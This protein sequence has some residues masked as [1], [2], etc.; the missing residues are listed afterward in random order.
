M[1]E[2]YNDLRQFA[3]KHGR[4]KWF[5]VAKFAWN[6][7]KDIVKTK[8]ILKEQEEVQKLLSKYNKGHQTPVTK[9]TRTQ[10]QIL[11]NPKDSCICPVCRQGYISFSTQWRWQTGCTRKCAANNSQ[12][13]NKAKETMVSKYGV[14]NPSLSNELS[15]K[16][17]RTVRKRY[18]VKNAFQSAEL[19]K[20]ARN[21]MKERYGVENPS[22]SKEILDRKKETSLRNCGYSHWTQD[23]NQQD[24]L[25]P[26]SQKTMKKARNTMKERYGVE[27]PFYLKSVQ[28]RIKKTMLERYGAT[29]IFGS[30]GFSERSA[31]T[32]KERYGKYPWEMNNPFGCK[33]YKDKNG[34]VHHVQGHEPWAL[35]WLESRPYKV[36]VVTG[37]GNVPTIRYQI[38]GKTHRYYPDIVAYT[39]TTKKI[40]EVKS[41]YTLYKAEGNWEINLAKFRAAN[42]YCKKHGFEFWLYIFANGRFIRI[43][44]PTAARI[45][46][47]LTF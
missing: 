6:M 37:S 26:F 10:L 1:Q 20:K 42:K 7:E 4:K 9:A 13:R 15:K 45:R 46:E 33:L 32:C 43:K 19:M 44:E 38:N 12:V 31:E 34:K 3:A 2:K 41:D 30:E 25:R 35:G 22:Q 29:N 11:F 28:N 40:I 16:R 8:R 5:L 27:N 39:K 24:R 17:E 36:R 47:H 18:G 14:E 23:P 21:T